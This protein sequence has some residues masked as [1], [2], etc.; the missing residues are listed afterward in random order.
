VVSMNWKAHLT[1]GLL[2]GVC[3]AYLMDWDLVLVSI[4]SGLGS[5]LPDID[6]KDSKITQILMFTFGVLLIYYL[7]QHVHLNLSDPM[8]TVNQLLRLIVMYVIIYFAF[9]GFLEV[10]RPRHRGITHTLIANIILVVVVYVYTQ[11]LELSLP[12]G[13]G[14]LSHLLTDRCIKLI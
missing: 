13:V 7:F 9:V 11:S 10:V 4:I 12:L 8:S 1:V 2:L 14:Y 6:H 5:L 3:L